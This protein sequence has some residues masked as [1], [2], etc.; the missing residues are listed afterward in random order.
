MVLKIRISLEGT[1]K[2]WD[3]KVSCFIL[4]YTL[5]WV[6]ARIE[7]CVERKRL[8]GLQVS[9]TRPATLL[10][11]IVPRFMQSS[12]KCSRWYHLRWYKCHCLP[13]LVLSE[14]RGQSKRYKTNP[15]ANERPWLCATTLT[16]DMGLP[17]GS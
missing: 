2:I 7:M 12:H 16:D 10:R 4:K 17:G 8:T 9:L 1:H 6:F 13:L 14:D 15:R 11:V 5:C 3:G